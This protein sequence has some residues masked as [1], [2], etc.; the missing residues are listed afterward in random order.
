MVG[1]DFVPEY[2]DSRMSLRAA[3]GLILR[4]LVMTL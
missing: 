2:E 4:M 3:P 1:E